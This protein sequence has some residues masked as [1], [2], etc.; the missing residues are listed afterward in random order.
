[1]V[2]SSEL[3]RK[4]IELLDNEWCKVYQ[5]ADGVVVRFYWRGRILKVFVSEVKVLG[6]VF[7][8]FVYLKNERPRVRYWFS[9]NYLKRIVKTADITNKT[10]ERQ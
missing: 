8:K 4:L 2:R 10:E 9:L 5:F 3:E 6:V 7:Y 1:M